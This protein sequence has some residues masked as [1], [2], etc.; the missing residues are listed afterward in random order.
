MKRTKVGMLVFA[1]F[2]LLDIAGPGDEFA[3]VRI[4]CKVGGSAEC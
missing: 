3:E 2:Q 4:L 1:G